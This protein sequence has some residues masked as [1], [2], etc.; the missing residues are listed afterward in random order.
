MKTLAILTI[1]ATALGAA[2]ML[3]APAKAQGVGIGVG[4]GGVGVT[5]NDGYRRDYR[6]DRDWRGSR[7]QY[8]EERRYRRDRDW[9]RRRGNRV[10]IERY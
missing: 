8:R 6:R 4:P 9:D 1:A 5:V 7:N 3:S 10:Y 2:S